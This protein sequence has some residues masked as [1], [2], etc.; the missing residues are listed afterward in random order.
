M[1]V[2]KNLECPKGGEREENSEKKTVY[3]PCLGI[4]MC[5]LSVMYG[6]F[7]CHKKAQ[8]LYYIACIS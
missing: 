1:K 8:S 2:H 6:I 7:I 3:H 4:N 5:E